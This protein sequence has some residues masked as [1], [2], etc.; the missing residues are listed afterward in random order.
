MLTKRNVFLG[1]L[2]ACLQSCAGAPPL[3]TGW[4]DVRTEHIHLRSNL[5][6]ELTRDTASQLQH[7]RDAIAAI[8]FECA[9]EGSFPPIEVTALDPANYEQIVGI[10]NGGIYKTS[11]LGWIGG[12]SAQIILRGI[13]GRSLAVFQHELAHRLVAACFPAAPVWLNEG[14]ATFFEG[15]AVE[16]NRVS[17]GLPVFLTSWDIGRPSS[18]MIDERRVIIVPRGRVT[19][20]PTL[21]A[22]THRNFYASVPGDPNSDSYNY[23]AAWALVH[24]LEVGEPGL[25]PGF[26]RYLTALSGTG[27]D[28]RR[29]WQTE[30]GALDLQSR[31]ES[32]LDHLDGTHLELEV[33]LAQRPRPIAKEMSP[34]AA[35]LHGAWLWGLSSQRSRLQAIAHAKR[36]LL[37]PGTSAGAHALLATAAL[38]EKDTARARLEIA[39]GL[40][41]A[42]HDPGLLSLQLKTELADGKPTAAFVQTL[43]AL[44]G[45]A[46]SPEA[47]ASEA[48]AEVVTGELESATRH[49]NA[50]VK[51]APEC[52]SCRLTRAKVLLALRRPDLAEHELQVVTNLLAH[53]G[54]ELLNE[55]DLMRQRVALLNRRRA[56]ETAN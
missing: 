10:D 40:R 4:A 20:L 52:W 15:T 11:P 46:F 24:L 49:S 29:V 45:V 39:L 41:L 44:R 13:G 51:A 18:M 3:A 21:L 26:G 27:D 31:F 23:A 50:A 22:T 36:A 7:A 38:T 55:V 6:L 56:L 35:E 1:P 33:N 30:F 5:G 47:L 32:Y 37:E 54:G 42:P 2:L 12:E 25:K 34:G 53:N 14:I 28:P 43:S 19:K 16:Q 8:G 17:T 9:T 48:E